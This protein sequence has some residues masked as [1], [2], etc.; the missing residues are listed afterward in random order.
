VSAADDSGTVHLTNPPSGRRRV[1]RHDSDNVAMVMSAVFRTKR[2]D[3]I[4]SGG[5]DCT[6]HLWDANKPR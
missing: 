3:E 4:A 1:L 2:K 5:T 6:V